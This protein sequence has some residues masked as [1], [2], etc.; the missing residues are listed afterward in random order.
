MSDTVAGDTRELASRRRHSDKLLRRGRLGRLENRGVITR[1]PSPG[2]AGKIPDGQGCRANAR[3]R[4]G[5]RSEAMHGKINGESNGKQ[6]RRP[7]AHGRTIVIQGN[8]GL[9]HCEW[10][11][12][13]AGPG[14][15]YRLWLDRQRRA[16]RTHCQSV[17]AL[18]G[19]GEAE[20]HWLRNRGMQ[21]FRAV[22]LRTCRRKRALQVR[23]CVVAGLRR[24]VA[25]RRRGQFGRYRRASQAESA[26]IHDR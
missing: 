5:G 9:V 19:P 13:L 15:V 1:P 16:S 21:G 6:A 25:T 4:H 2:K 8:A 22:L 23:R 17:L 12:M 20:A 3:K 11:L 14:R 24:R 18:A 26:L 7:M 10:M